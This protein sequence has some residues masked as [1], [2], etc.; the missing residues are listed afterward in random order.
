LSEKEEDEIEEIPEEEPAEPIREETNERPIFDLA[1][2]LR[3]RKGRE[4]LPITE[5]ILLMDYLDRAE[6]RRIRREGLVNKT[7]TKPQ[8]L[9]SIISRAVSNA[10]KPLVPQTRRSGEMPEE[11]KKL[12]DRLEGIEKK[13]SA[14]EQEKR[15]RELIEKVTH[16]LHDQLKERDMIIEKLR[17]ELNDLREK[18]E[19]LGTGG[20]GGKDKLDV[21]LEVDEKI[22][23]ALNKKKP[24]SVPYLLNP[25][26]ERI[27]ITGEIPAYLAYGPV[28]V[29][30]VIQA[31][32]EGIEEIAK[33]LIQIPA[34][35]EPQPPPK[36]EELI[37]LP[38]KPPIP[39][40]TKEEAPIE[41][42]K[43]AEEKAKAEAKPEKPEAPKEELIKIPEKP[44]VEE[45]QANLLMAT[46]ETKYT[47]E[48]L[49][50]KKMPELWSIAKKLGIPKKGKKSELIDKILKASGEEEDERKDNA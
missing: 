38:P 17:E 10:I 3:S 18:Y 6:E 28:I 43:P 5:A 22:E 49:E 23:R 48:D 35:Q 39:E 25:E 12:M 41:E 46:P 31:A 2:I 7:E 21:Y 16:P 4:P 34:Q 20:G 37:Q 26:G 8:D 24:K 33:R 1:S 9:A 32:K 50:K 13:L 45:A 19:N 15:Q 36:R 14:E 47:R 42:A 40:E 11:L 27:P 29:R 30:Q 44:K